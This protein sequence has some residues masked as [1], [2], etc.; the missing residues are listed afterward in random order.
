MVKLTVL[1]GSPT[2]PAA[3]DK[4]YTETHIPLGEALPGLRRF[5]VSKVS[6]T[7]D[8][9]PAPYHL[10]ADLYFDDA[11]AVKAAFESSEGRAAG[12]DVANFATGG[13]TMFVSE[14]V[15]A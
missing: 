1:Y 15:K 13:A 12:A 10:Q 14:V 3:F 5:E 9:S 6:G 4:Y 8:G 7:P 2:D 11:T